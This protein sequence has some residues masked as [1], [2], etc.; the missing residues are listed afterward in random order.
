MV[1]S[2]KKP[3][4]AWVV[5]QLA[6]PVF[7]FVVVLMPIAALIYAMTFGSIT[8]LNYVHIM[9]GAVWTGIDLFM[10]IVIGPV[11]GGTDPQ[12]RATVFRRLIPRMTFLMPVLAT[13]TL[14]SGIKLAEI[15]RG[16]TVF[17]LF[18]SPL[19][20]WIIAAA[21]IAFILTVQG[22]GVMLPNEVRIFRQLLSETPDI[23]KISR[24]GM[25]NAKLGGIQGLLQVAIILIM[26]NIRF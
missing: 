1:N 18:A 3:N 6:N 21:V 17:N 23:E 19:Q 5:I 22:F 24:L 14:T 8:S 7:V 2:A 26:A 16:I 10:G 15:M 25:R 12:T 9:T 4:I 20:P 11:L 13:I